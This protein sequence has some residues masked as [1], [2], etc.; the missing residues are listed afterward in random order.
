[1]RTLLTLC[2]LVGLSLGVIGCSDPAPTKPAG[3]PPD[4]KLGKGAKEAKEEKGKAEEKPAAPAP[5]PEAKKEE[6]PKEAPK[7]EPKKEEPKKEEKKD[8][9]KKAINTKCPLSG[10][11]VDAAAVSVYKSQTIAFCCGNC[12]GKF[13]AE[14]AKFIAKVAEFKEPK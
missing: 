9:K 13:D 10:K 4:I 11:D 8:D 12:K 7:E 3:P 1:M 14:P 6:P 2:T 5:A